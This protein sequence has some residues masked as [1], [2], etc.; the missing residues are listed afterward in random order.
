MLWGRWYRDPNQPIPRT[1]ITRFPH[2]VLE[3]KLSLPEGQTAP[4]WVTDL[5][6]SGILTEVGPVYPHIFPILRVKVSASPESS[7][8]TVV[9]VLT[10]EKK[11]EK[12]MPFG[13]H[14]GSLQI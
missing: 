12:S 10:T 3:V 4:E 5:T 6:E 9:Q 1:D 7:F 14:N 8:L 13:D 11:K 2:A